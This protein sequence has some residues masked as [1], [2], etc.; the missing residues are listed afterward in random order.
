MR[1]SAKGEY[2]ILALFE[3][4]LHEGDSPLQA[5]TI[6]K[7]QHIPLR[8]LEQVLSSLKKAGLVESTRG[9][10]GGYVLAKPAS[11]I[12][13]SDI[14]QANEGPIAPTACVAGTE[15]GLCPH[16]LENGECILKPIGEQVRSSVL[17]VLNSMTLQ[18][19]CD[20]KR[21]RDQQKILMYHI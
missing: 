9:A 6:A 10:Q 17:E 21:E 20:R 15:D 13:I 4:A 7:K 18:D 14:L 11:E 3:L 12:R 5:K 19:L 8:F 2:G 1:F 16:E